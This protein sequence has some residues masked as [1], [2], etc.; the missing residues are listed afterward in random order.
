[1][2]GERNEKEHRRL[3]WVRD[4]GD[5]NQRHA[6]G[7]LCSLRTLRDSFPSFR[8]GLGAIELPVGSILGGDFPAPASTAWLTAFRATARTAFSTASLT[9]FRATARTA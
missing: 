7:Q 2:V 8:W 1:M 4:G 6:E 3:P 9:A 5:V